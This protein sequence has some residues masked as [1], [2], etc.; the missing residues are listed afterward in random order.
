MVPEHTSAAGRV[1]RP[2]RRAVPNTCRGLPALAGCHACR[3]AFVLLAGVRVGAGVDARTAD[4]L[5]G[6][7]G[8]PSLFQLEDDA[9][10]GVVPRGVDRNAGR[11]RH[12]PPALADRTGVESRSAVRARASPRAAERPPI[13]ARF[14]GRGSGVMAGV[15]ELTDAVLCAGGRLPH[16]LVCRLATKGGDWP[17]TGSYPPVRPTSM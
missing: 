10:R 7:V 4:G 9:A 12:G 5:D 15:F 1:N 8:Q 3:S 17:T 16:W 2:T 13:T 11:F 14:S 6:A